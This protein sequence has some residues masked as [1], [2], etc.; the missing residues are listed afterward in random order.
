MKMDDGKKKDAVKQGSEADGGRQ[1]LI[2]DAV[3]VHRAQQEVLSE[4]DEESREK[5]TAMAETVMP[6]PTKH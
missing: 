3:S 4:L 5:L 6:P 1:Q 2:E